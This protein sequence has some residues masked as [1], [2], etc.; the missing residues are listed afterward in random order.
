MKNQLSETKSKSAH[1]A[2]WRLSSKLA[3]FGAVTVICASATA[4]NL[5]VSGRD[6]SGGK[7]FKFT[8]NRVQST[9]ASGL[10]GPQGLAFDKAGNLFVANVVSGTGNG[11]GSIYKFTPQGVRSTFASGLDFPLDLA[12]DS[13]GNLFVTDYGAGHIYKFTPG[14]L[15]TT[16]ASLSNPEG[17]AFDNTGDLFVG[18]VG[19]GYIYKFTPSGVRTT[20]ASGFVGEIN[21]ACDSAGNLFVSGGFGNGINV[22][23]F[24]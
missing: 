10:S 17:L 4:Q 1:R 13:A 16:F 22:Y 23:K 3:C 19:T 7:I 24:T 21:L 5:F 15:R 12:F 14:E 20:F 9:F 2:T 6:T 11:N 8:P 18:E